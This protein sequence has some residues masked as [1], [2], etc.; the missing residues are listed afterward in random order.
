MFEDAI[1]QAKELDLYQKQNGVKGPL[2]GLPVSMKDSFKIKGYDATIGMLHFTNNPATEDSILISTL[3]SLGA[4]LYCKTNVPQTMM[5]ADS[6]N[7]IWGRTLNPN[8]KSLTSGGSTGGEGA[9]IAMR[10]SIAGFGTDIA[11]SIRIPALCCGIYGFKPTSSR[12]PFGGQ[13]NPVAPGT[14]GIMPTTGPMATSVQSCQMLMEAVMKTEPW[15]YDPYSLA[16]PWRTTST[17]GKLRI[18]LMTSD[19]MRTPTWPIQ[20]P[21]AQAAEKL[22]RAGHDIVKVDPPDMLGTM[23]DTWKLFALDGNQVSTFLISDPHISILR[24]YLKVTRWCHLSKQ[25]D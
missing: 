13:Q 5:T 17:K 22:T 3:R 4:I 19:T 6:E 9:L 18:G 2:H 10:G 20:K 11:G 7:N 14:T 15:N 25:Q 12:L 16:I 21:M 23:E 24:R 8:N 1:Q